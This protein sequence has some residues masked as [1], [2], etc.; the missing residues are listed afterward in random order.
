MRLTWKSTLALAVVAGLIAFFGAI[1]VQEAW[2]QAKGPADFE[3]AGGAQGKVLF[4]HEKHLP[5]RPKC[6]DCHTKIFKMTKGQRSAPK[7]ADM[8]NGQ[9]CGACHE[10]KAAFSVKDQASCTKC[11]K[12]G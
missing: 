4:S 9:S 12:K 6:T 3:F 7:M 10:G 11:H 2:A 1:V 8:N 5:K